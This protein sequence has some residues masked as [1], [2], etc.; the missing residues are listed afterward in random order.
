MTTPTLQAA[1]ARM[2]RDRF[3]TTGDRARRI[4]LVDTEVLTKAILEV[5]EGHGK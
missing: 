1:L 5:V 4:V 2:L 3:T